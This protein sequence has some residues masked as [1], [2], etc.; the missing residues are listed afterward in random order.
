LALQNAQYDQIMR[1]YNRRQL[2]NK[3]LF[4][5]HRKKAYDEI[6]RLAEIDDEIATLSIKKAHSLL[7]G[8][9]AD[10]DL[11]T[12]IE[13]LSQERL[14]LLVMHDY[15]KDYLMMKYDCPKCKD[16]GYVG[17]TKCPCFQKAATELLYAQSNI[18]DL[19]TTHNF[20]NFSLDYYDDDV[21]ASDTSFTPRETA[22]QAFRKVHQFIDFFSEQNDNLFLYGHTGV[23]KTFLSHC[24]AKELLD[25]GFCVIY[26][27]AF[28]LFDQFA[29]GTFSNSAEAA[30]QNEFILNCDLLIIDDLGTELTNRFVGSAL[31]LCINERLMRGKS[32]II[33]TNLSIEDFAETY[34]ER[35]LSRISSKYTMIKL[36]GKDIRI[37]K[38]YGDRK[39]VV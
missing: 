25:K 3:H 21:I 12:A 32:T 16:T 22:R 7:G 29:K 2:N 14:A 17:G 10:W 34:S 37:Q 28:D 9:S 5:E 23:G 20:K 26:F 24:I 19:I 27:S 1:D 33:S 38:T 35:I 8:P 15:P 13:T 30:G 11:A 36:I 18:K 31:F 6:P 4:D 39:S